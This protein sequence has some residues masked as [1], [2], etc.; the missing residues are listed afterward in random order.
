MYMQEVN[1]DS[2]NHSDTEIVRLDTIV[3]DHLV[4]ILSLV[5]YVIISGVISVLGIAFNIVN[6]VVFIKL[7]F[8]DTVNIS[9]LAL[10][11]AELQSLLPLVWNGVGYNPILINRHRN[12]NFEMILYITAAWPH[13]CF[14]RIA[15]WLIAFVT[16]ER[17]L[18][19]ALPLKVKTIISPRRTRATVVSIF[20][21][22]TAAFV[23]EYFG[24]GVGP[25]VNSSNNVSVISLT[26]TSSGHQ[27]ENVLIYF[28]T[29]SQFASFLS[30]AVSTAGLVVTFGNKI[31]WRDTSVTSAQK[32][33]LSSRDKRTIKMVIG[34]STIFIISYLPVTISQLGMLFYRDYNFGRRYHNLLV[35]T[36]TVFF[37]LESVNSS[38]SIFVYYNLSSRYRDMFLKIAG[39]GTAKPK[40]P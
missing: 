13:I 18:C 32:S 34:I 6:I 31:K 38:S 39:L 21:I 8:T 11:V 12:I 22:F 17:Y 40:H 24:V 2:S 33:T 15:A 26:Y 27:I 20:A 4:S 9:L 10:A 23:L 7:G 37:C 14:S 3:S 35:A 28:A 5:N 19:V 29:F 36:S 1:M 16:F 25:H 30:V